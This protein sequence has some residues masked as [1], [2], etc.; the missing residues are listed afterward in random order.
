MDVES[1]KLKLNCFVLNIAAIYYVAG[2]YC[3]YMF[4]SVRMLCTPNA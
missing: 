3:S 1:K 2:I 4:T